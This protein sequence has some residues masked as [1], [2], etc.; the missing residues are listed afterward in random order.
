MVL[1]QHGVL[2]YQRLVFQSLNRVRFRYQVKV[3]ERVHLREEL[4][5]RVRMRLGIL[6]EDWGWG[7]GVVRGGREL[8]TVSRC[9]GEQN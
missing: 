4:N 1:K 7:W 3:R 2:K 6:G 9:R 8:G 5:V